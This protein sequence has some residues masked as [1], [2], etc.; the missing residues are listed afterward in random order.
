MTGKMQGGSKPDRAQ[1]V[2]DDEQREP[3]KTSD[4]P[5]RE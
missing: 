3:G 2:E 5:A 4:T 1:E